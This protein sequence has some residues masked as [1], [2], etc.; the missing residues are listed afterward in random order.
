[1]SDEEQTMEGSDRPLISQP[2]APSEARLAMEEAQKARLARQAEELAEYQASRQEAIA[3]ENEEINAL[4]DKRIQRQ[5]EREEEEKRMAEAR[6]QQE[7][8]RRA[9]EEA[10]KQKK[11][12]EELRIKEE[13]E[14][15]R[16]EAEERMKPKGRSFKITKKSD[17]EKEPKKLLDSVM[18]KEELQKSKEQLEDEKQAI[19]A[20]RIQALVLDGLSSDKMIEKAKELNEQIR[21]LEGDKY[22]LEQRFKRQ[23]YDMIELAE[24]ARQ[25]NKGK[26]KRSAVQ[27]DDSFDR[28]GDKFTSAPPKVQLCSKYDKHTDHRSYA[29]RKTVFEEFSKEK[30][31]ERK[32]P[33][34]VAEVAEGEGE[35]EAEAEAEV[36]PAEAEAE[37]V[38]AEE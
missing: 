17:S 2:G 13:R 30:V 35:G 4:R 26:G 21:R 24:R 5:K 27:V 7:V 25:M 14:T 32:M 1:M 22:D 20:Q 29:E 33:K 8:K 18:S 11:A 10:L 23:Q 38:V 37:A 3:K 12:E 9:D 31:V 16:R 36:A 34:K 19:L 28:L 15:K 6:E